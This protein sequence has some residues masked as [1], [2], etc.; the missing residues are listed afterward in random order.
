MTRTTDNEIWSIWVGDSSVSEFW[1]DAQEVYGCCTAEE[2]VDT[3]LSELPFG[4]R[5]SVSSADMFKVRRALIRCV[6]DLLENE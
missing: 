5:E 4:Q 1:V 6:E 3:Y 2:A